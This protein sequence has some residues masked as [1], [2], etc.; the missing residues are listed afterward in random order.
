MLYFGDSRFSLRPVAS[1][2]S[3]TLLPV[4]PAQPGA[5]GFS[6]WYWLDNQ[7]LLGVAELPAESPAVGM[8]AAEVESQPPLAVVLSVYDMRTSALLPV[9]IG[10]DL[11]AVFEVDGVRAGSVEL[12]VEGEVEPIWATLDAGGAE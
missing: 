4:R 7:R 6:D 12:R 10:E 2:D 11:P 3:G 5:T 1:L 8:T 9:E